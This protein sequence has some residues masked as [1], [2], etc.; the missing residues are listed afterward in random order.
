MS[1]KDDIV[2]HDSFSR[3]GLKFEKVVIN[4]ELPMAG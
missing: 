4:L 2:E 1:K 3:A